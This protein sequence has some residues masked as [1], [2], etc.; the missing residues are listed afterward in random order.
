MEELIYE[1]E[2]KL[3]EEGEFQWIKDSRLKEY[4]THT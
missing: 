2:A 1:H 4:P 3:Y